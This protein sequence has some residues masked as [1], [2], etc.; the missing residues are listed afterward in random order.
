MLGAMRKPTFNPGAWE[1]QR[2]RCQIPLDQPPV[3]DGAVSLSDVA[4]RLLK[5]WGLEGR[6][7]EE[8]LL[9]EWPQ[10]VGAQ[11]AG[12][13]RPGRMDRGTL[14]IFVDSSVWLSELARFVRGPLL[15]NVQRLC[16]ADKVR[17]I[18]LQLD[19]EPPRPK[20]AG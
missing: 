4:D 7:W 18:R 11:V 20:P 8:R 6:A 3:P 16:G 2:E 1:M 12:H 17:R 15:T 5:K 14:V 19:P 10:V 9:R 13:S